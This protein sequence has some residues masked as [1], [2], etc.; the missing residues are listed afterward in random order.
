M[1]NQLLKKLLDNLPDSI[2]LL[3]PETSNIVY[4][5][6]MGY[7]SLDLQAD[8]VLNHSVLTLQKDV[9][10][11]P[12]WGEIAEQIRQ[13]EVFTF[14]GRHLRKNGSEFPVEVNTTTFQHDGNE[15][16]LSVARDI[17]NR[18]LDS[19]AIQEDEKKLWFLLNETSDGLWDWNL[20]TDMVYFSPQL[21]HM[22]GYGPD[23]MTPDI[24]TWSNNIHPEDS[25][26]VMRAIT[27]HIEGRRERYEAEYRLKN[28]NGHYL[29]VHD[30]GKVSERN[31]LGEPQRM[32]GMVQNITERK[33]LEHR[34]QEMAS[35]DD[36]T[37]IMNRREGDFILEKQIDFS[38]RL[39][40][41]LGICLFDLDHFKK[42]NDKYGHLTGDQVLKTVAK[43]VSGIIRKLDYFYRWGGEEF[44]LILP[45]TSMDQLQII[46]EK[47]R[48]AIEIYPW[49]E[50]LAIPGV[51][52]SFGL[53]VYPQH[54]ITQ[55]ELIL[56]AD[57]AM[58]QAKSSGRNCVVASQLEK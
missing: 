45:D 19:G 9:S 56:N 35:H 22:L 43:I 4:C 3:D 48:L 23:E 8:E 20:S 7:E 38:K 53:S 54:G 28:R 1:N 42:I 6:R 31:Q 26:R 51:T 14:I 13:L 29:W 57:A 25:Q 36:L 37:G 41:Q 58:F 50:K 12:A 34:L 17:T 52:A 24:S 16:F 44:V 49:Q 40:L 27:D 18:H 33:N 2:Y 55:Q 5:N 21:K 30:R 11:M 32:V 47:I 46:A 10:G 15:Y 39:N